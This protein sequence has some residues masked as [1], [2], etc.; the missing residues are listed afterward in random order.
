[1]FLVNPLS[2]EDTVRRVE[3]GKSAEVQAVNDHRPKLTDRNIGGH[4][5]PVFWCASSVCFE[6]SV[7]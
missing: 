4:M 5:K 1:V 6:W 2:S 7:V 3:F